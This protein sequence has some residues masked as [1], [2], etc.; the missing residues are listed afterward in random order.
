M[1]VRMLEHTA[2]TGVIAD[3]KTFGEALECAAA[4]MFTLMGKAEAPGGKSTIECRAQ[5]R[6]SL[7]VF[8]LSEILSKCESDSITPL[9]L[10]V[11]QCTDQYAKAEL[12]YS[13]KR[14]EN[15]IKAVTFHMLH[16]KHGQGKWEIQVLFDI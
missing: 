2:D 14:P 15:I 5:D 10:S 6:E 12:S 11:A 4:G 9:S 16:V 13:K 1:G 7:V 8:L 3:G